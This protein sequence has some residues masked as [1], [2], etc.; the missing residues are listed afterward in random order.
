MQAQGNNVTVVC[1]LRTGQRVTDRQPYGVKHVVKLRNGVARHLDAPHRFLCLTDQVEQVEAAG[2]CAVA[3]PN[4]WRGWW[5]KI[6]LFTPDMLTEST[7]YLD[8]DSLVTGDL[9]PL[10]RTAPG[11][12]MVSDFTQPQMMNSSAMAWKGDFSAVWHKFR[13]DPEATMR[14]YDAL[15]SARVGDQGFTHDALRA[16][17]A[18]IDTFDPAHVVSFKRSAR[19]AAPPD[20]RVLSFHGT[21]KTDSPE[22]GWAFE[23]WNAL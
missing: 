9:L 8:L 10:L 20:A 22:A 5:S 12:T 2:I 14:H 11:I 13:I 23:A 21:P 1:V 7:L 19:E 17:G 6:N 4:P 18:V 16:T 15:P 3:L